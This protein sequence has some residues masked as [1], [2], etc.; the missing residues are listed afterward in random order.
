MK[1]K[2]ERDVVEKVARDLM[3]VRRGDFIRVADEMGKLAK[4]SMGEDGLSYY[5]LDQ[6]RCLI[7]RRNFDEMMSRVE[8]RTK[9][10]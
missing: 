1:D 2:C 10:E 4:K 3:E 5:N 8:E 9:Y 6:H 7:C